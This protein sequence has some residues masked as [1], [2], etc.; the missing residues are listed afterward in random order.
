VA[1][2]A[3]VSLAFWLALYSLIAVYVLAT[4]RGAPP[5][6][7]ALKWVA[8]VG[9]ASAAFATGDRRIA[10]SGILV[11]LFFFPWVV[12]ALT[13]QIVLG[14][15]GRGVGVGGGYLGLLLMAFVVL[16]SALPTLAHRS[17]FERRLVAALAVMAL[18]AI[19]ASVRD[20]SHAVVPGV[21]GRPM[22]LRWAFE[23]VNTGGYVGYLGAFLCLRHVHARRLRFLVP[24]ALF[25][26]LLISSGSRG[27]LLAFATAVLV[28]EGAMLLG[29]YGVRILALAAGV[30]CV[31][32][33][34]IVATVPRTLGQFSFHS[35]NEL[36]SGRL[37]AWRAA[38]GRLHGPDE[39]LFG[40]GTGQNVSFTGTHSTVGGSSDSLV[41]DMLTR[42]GIIGMVIWIGTMFVISVLLGMRILSFGQRAPEH[43]PVL[44]FASGLFVSV[45]VASM[46]EGFV[47]SVGSTFGLLAW[48]CIGLA[49]TV[50][51]AGPGE[52]RARGSVFA[53]D[54]SS[55]E[56]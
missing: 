34:T 8:L 49:C 35:V 4:L 47:F 1:R 26:L 13:V 22:R 51:A 27:A 55:V 43:L 15:T 30:G 19:V 21:A 41:V 2:E 52:A 18:F 29:R 25:L 3:R 17:V 23:H 33:A 6:I 39:W 10:L 50:D 53:T 32:L 36:L 44:L 20:P 7:Y 54:S 11:P 28:T 42:T 14:P 9:L 38:L 46:F 5:L 48:A 12:V 37:W 31:L 24:F 45:L 16:P 40:L 56:R